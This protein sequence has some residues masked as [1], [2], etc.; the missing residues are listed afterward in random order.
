MLTTIAL[1]ASLLAQPAPQPAPLDGPAL[2]LAQPAWAFA[3]MRLP[4]S[5]EPE[6]VG[7]AFADFVDEE[8]A[9]A[10]MASVTPFASE[11]SS[12]PFA[13]LAVYAQPVLVTSHA[14]RW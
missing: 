10:L 1:L 7:A 8:R 13:S 12:Q 14:E 4:D 5:Y 3:P 6:W 9:G 11:D 2:T